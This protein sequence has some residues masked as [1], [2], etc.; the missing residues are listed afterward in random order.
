MSLKQLICVQT[1]FEFQTKN[2][3]SEEDLVLKRKMLVQKLLGQNKCLITKIWGKQKHL[4]QQNIGSQI[5]W[6][7]KMTINVGV[8]KR[9]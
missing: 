7:Q 8:V 9:F 3:E 6:L 4:G 2:V 1:N 5:L